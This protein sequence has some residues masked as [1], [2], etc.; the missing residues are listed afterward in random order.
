MRH[1]EADSRDFITIVQV[2]DWGGHLWGIE[3][4]EQDVIDFDILSVGG[5]AARWVGCALILPAA[6]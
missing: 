1:T 5:L 3:V 2:N 4:S 6:D